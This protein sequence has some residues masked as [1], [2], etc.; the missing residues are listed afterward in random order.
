[1]GS[2]VSI[3]PLNLTDADIELLKKKSQFSRDEI[4]NWHTRFMVVF[5]LLPY[6]KSP[7]Y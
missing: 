5:R 2:S 1:M 6:K 7:F 3:N 4:I